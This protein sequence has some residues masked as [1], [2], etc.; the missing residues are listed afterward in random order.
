MENLVNTI[1]R[2]IR[3][4][5]EKKGIS[6]EELAFRADVHRA[7]IGQVERAERNLTISSLEKIA[8]GLEIKVEELF[9]LK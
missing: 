1:G 7:Y 4:L 9:N 3:I 2:S 6:Q 5:R 8:N